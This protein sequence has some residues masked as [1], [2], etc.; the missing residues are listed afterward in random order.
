[1]FDREILQERGPV[2]TDL[3]IDR[4]TLPLAGVVHERLR[5]LFAADSLRTTGR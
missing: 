5:D 2:V 1:M 4:A 3:E